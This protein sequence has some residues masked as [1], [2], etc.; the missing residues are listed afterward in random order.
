MREGFGLEREFV[1]PL[2]W[3]TFLQTALKYTCTWGWQMY[4]FVV[5]GILIY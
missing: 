1:S 3:L 4:E 2:R 5:V